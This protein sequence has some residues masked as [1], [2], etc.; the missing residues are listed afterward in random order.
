MKVV[1]L[2]IGI[3]LERRNK[4]EIRDKICKKNKEIR[5]L[6][7]RIYSLEVFIETW[8]DVLLSNMSEKYLNEQ[9]KYKRG[10]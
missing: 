10:K 1:L 3:N 4:M 6:K 5:K 2:M 9:L 8:K 7:E